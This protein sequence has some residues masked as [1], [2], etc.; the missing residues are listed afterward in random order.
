MLIKSMFKYE[1]V[2]LQHCGPTLLLSHTA[3]IYHVVGGRMLA[4]TTCKSCVT[5]KKAAAQV[6]SQLMGQLPAARLTP[7]AV[8]ET[9]GQ[10]Y[11]GPF[12]IKKGHTR[13]P[14]LIK[15]YLSI[16][17]CFST[18]AVH[19]EVVSD[20]TTAT[21]LAALDRFIA[22]RGRPK[23]IHTDN[24]LNFV[25]AKNQLQQWVCSSHQI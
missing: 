9:T 13:R 10:D 2:R 11:A 6:Q 19:L 18:R 4:W 25:G 20:L 23:A 24:G 5:C 15:S 17:V 12:I 14:V 3:G 1:H 8:F 21:F 16:F 7:S 22:R